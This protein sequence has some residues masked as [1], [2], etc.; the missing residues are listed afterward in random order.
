MSERKHLTQIEVE[1]L[2]TAT[3]GSRNEQCSQL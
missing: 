2:M 3:K 1:R